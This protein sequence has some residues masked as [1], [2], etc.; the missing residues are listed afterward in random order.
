M[1]PRQHPHAVPEQARIGRI[2]DVGLDDRLKTRSRPSI[3]KLCSLLAWTRAT[4]V[5]Q[6]WADVSGVLAE[7]RALAQRAIQADPDDPWSH[8]AAG[9]VYM[10]SRD[11]DHAVA[12]LTEA[13]DLNSSFAFAHVILGAVYGYG[14]MRKRVSII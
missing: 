9:Y 6:G 2:V 12:E 3:S 10:M 1:G 14:G 7:A 13:I 8:F 5:H 11:L 4:A